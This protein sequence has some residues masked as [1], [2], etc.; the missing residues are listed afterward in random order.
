MGTTRDDGSQQSMWVATTDLPRNASASLIRT[1]S[2]TADSPVDERLEPLVIVHERIDQRVQPLHRLLRPVQPHLDPVPL[3]RHPLGQARQFPVEG[4][5]GKCHPDPG[6]PRLPELGSGLVPAVLLSRRKAARARCL[7]RWRR[8]CVL[9][10]VLW[11]PVS[12]APRSRACPSRAAT[13]SHQ[14]GRSGL[15]AAPAGQAPPP[16][17]ATPA[18]Q[19]VRRSSPISVARGFRGWRTTSRPGGSRRPRLLGVPDAHR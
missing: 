18:R 4:L 2:P 10:S 17:T 19:Q 6:H 9:G 8:S 15:D 1:L 16:E 12:S 7:R 3:D 5:G 14:A 11:L 13:G